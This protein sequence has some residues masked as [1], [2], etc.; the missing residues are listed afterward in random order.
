VQDNSPKRVSDYSKLSRRLSQLPP[1]EKIHAKHARSQSS[2][3][4]S[5]RGLDRY[6]K[7]ALEKFN[8]WSPHQVH[9]RNFSMTYG[10]QKKPDRFGSKAMLAAGGFTDVLM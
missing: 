7:V 10:M 8:P 2:L 5:G 6:D 3:G 1:I 9:L 4:S